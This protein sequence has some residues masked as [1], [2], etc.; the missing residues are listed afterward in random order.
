MIP[1]DP[2]AASSRLWA[3]AVGVLTFLAF[4]RVLGAG[5]VPWDDPVNITGNPCFRGFSAAHVWWMLTT[6]FD[7]HYIPLVWLSFALDHAVWGMNPFGYHLSN[8]LLHSANAVTAYVVFVRILGGPDTAAP[9]LRRRAAAAVGALLFSLHPLRVESVAW[10]TERRDVLSGF[11]TLLSLMCYLKAYDSG[12]ASAGRWKAWCL[13]FFGAMVLSRANAATLAGTFVLVD[14]FILGRRGADL[15]KEKLPFVL[16]GAAAVGVSMLAQSDIAS[17]SGARPWSHR[18]LT[19]LFAGGFYLWKTLW[20]AG[21]SPVY[22]TPDQLHLNNPEVVLCVILFLAVAAGI[23]LLRRPFLSF[24]FLHYVITFAPAAGGVE[25]WSVT[26]DRYSYLACLFWAAAAGKALLSK[27]TLRRGVLAATAMA[28]LIAATWRQ[29]GVWRDGDSLWGRAVSVRP[30][31]CVAWT[32]YG[33]YLVTE[34]RWKEA[35]ET[36]DRALAIQPRYSTAWKVRGEAR[37]EQGDP[38]ALSDLLE[39]VRLSPKDSE[40]QQLLGDCYLRRRDF[41][42][43]AGCFEKAAPL[44]REAVR[45]NPAN[46]RAWN[47]LGLLELRAGRPAAAETLLRRAVAL[48]PGFGETHSHLAVALQSQGRFQEALLHH[49]EAVR[50]EPGVPQ[51]RFNAAVLLAHVGRSDLARRHLEAALAMDPSMEEARILLKSLEEKK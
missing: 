42:R 11:F 24:S 34:R 25:A 40:N 32:S 4:S 23:L 12:G 51:I 41:V 6:L 20:P 22:L 37:A 36:A 2:D 49:L 8:V 9:D 27:T 13:A 21:L 17:F 50:L 7:G 29:E 16:I 47:D 38:R 18:A 19:F 15:W 5:F 44:L 14:W 39:A 45:R 26:Y 31:S 10:V 3:V 1:R 46:A 28:L 48:E 33:L 35:E 30:G 43:A